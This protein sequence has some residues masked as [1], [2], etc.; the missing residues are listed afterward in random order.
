VEIVLALAGFLATLIGLV[1][2]WR[3]HTE[4]LLHEIRNLLQEIRD[5]LPPPASP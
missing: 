4:R 2:T 1:L 3:S 5:R